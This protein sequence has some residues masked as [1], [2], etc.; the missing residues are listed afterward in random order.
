MSSPATLMPLVTNGHWPW[1][2]RLH[3]EMLGGS[4]MGFRKVRWRECRWCLFS[5]STSLSCQEAPVRLNPCNY[6]WSVVKTFFLLEES[7]EDDEPWFVS[8][9]LVDDSFI[10]ERKAA[11]ASLT[12][13]SNRKATRSICRPSPWSCWKSSDF[14]GSQLNW[15]W[16]WREWKTTR[17]MLM[18]GYLGLYI[19]HISDRCSNSRGS[20]DLTIISVSLF[21]NDRRNWGPWEGWRPNEVFTAALGQG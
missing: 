13:S 20:E 15:D 8:A 4:P 1:M 19:L 9:A 7:F 6:Y 11:L 16:K 17:W 10:G 3:D 21:S 2:N 14:G 5:W 18:S 12:F